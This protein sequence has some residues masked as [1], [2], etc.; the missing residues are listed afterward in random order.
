MAAI[1]RQY[2]G[3][4]KYCWPGELLGSADVPEP[5]FRFQPPVALSRHAAGNQ[6]LCGDGLP[7]LEIRAASMLMLFST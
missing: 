1:R 4:V 3:D 5:E 7:V 6:R 2:S